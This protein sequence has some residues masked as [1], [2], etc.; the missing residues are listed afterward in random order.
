MKKGKTRKKLAF[1]DKLIIILIFVLALLCVVYIAGQVIMQSNFFGGEEI[2]NH[3]PSSPSSTTD[4]S[5]T[6]KGSVNQTD[7]LSESEVVEMS[8]NMVNILCIGFDASNALSDVL[9]LVSLNTETNAVN[10]LQIPRDSY[11]G[12]WSTGK[13]NSAYAF[14][15]KPNSVQNIIDEIN[16]E[17]QLPVTHYMSIGLDKFADVVDAVGGIE[18]N[19]P[20]TIPS[21]GYYPTIYAGEQKLYG[22]AAEWL[23]RHRSSYPQAD[24]GREKMQRVFLAACMQKAKELG[25]D[26]VVDILPEV[27]G[28]FKTDM[29][30]EELIKLAKVFIKV[31]MENVQCFMLP[32]EAVWERDIAY[33]NTNYYNYSVYSIHKEDTANLLNMHFRPF[34]NPVPAENLS[35]FEIVKPQDYKVH[36]SV[37]E[38]SKTFED[39]YTNPTIK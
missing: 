9:M 19:V 6:Q 37:D 21:D 28:D 15:K 10:I 38:D 32:G 29:N 14:G 30:T 24:I 31:D 22:R 20:V 11:M 2:K 25:I 27:Y 16:Q 12:D 18:V 34:Q 13:I 39:L 8:K 26:E 4:F 33:E 17:F 1:N 35:I 36:Y 3:I 5:V 7:Y 23:V